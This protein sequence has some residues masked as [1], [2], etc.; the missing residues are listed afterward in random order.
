MPTHA[1]TISKLAQA[2]GV[3]IETIRYYQRRGLLSEPSRVD[4]GFRAYDA[5]HLQ[6]LQFIRRAQEL[7]FS[8]DDAAELGSLSQTPDRARLRGVAR[9]RAA[10][11]RQRISELEAMALALE[12]LAQ[13]C[14]RTGPGQTCPIMAALDPNKRQVAAA[15]HACA[16]A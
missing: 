6:Q 4:G 1:F 7:G 2:A 11:I 15:P 8:L 12:Q 14:Q 9:V 3:N 5:R 13:T 16:E 10:D